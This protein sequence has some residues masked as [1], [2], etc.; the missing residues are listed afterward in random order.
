MEEPAGSTQ[1]KACSEHEATVLQIW[2]NR[3]SSTEH[4]HWLGYHSEN[5]QQRNAERQ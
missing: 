2:F 1:E 3:G 4:D 5:G